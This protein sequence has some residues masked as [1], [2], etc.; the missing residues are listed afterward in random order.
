[1]QCDFKTCPLLVFPEICIYL[2][3]DW[4]KRKLN[5]REIISRDLTPE[6]VF[7]AVAA[8]LPSMINGFVNYSAIADSS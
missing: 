3:K 4:K 5:F 1:M 8:E 6:V 2:L 7:P